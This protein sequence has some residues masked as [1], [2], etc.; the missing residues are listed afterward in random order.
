MEPEPESA[1]CKCG[2]RI[3]KHNGEWKHCSCTPVQKCWCGCDK[4]E[5][6]GGSE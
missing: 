2:H 5:P 4:P 3:E 1:N 6:K